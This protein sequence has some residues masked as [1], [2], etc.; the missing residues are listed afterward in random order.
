MKKKGKY[1]YIRLKGEQQEVNPR[2]TISPTNKQ[3]S[4]RSASNQLF[5]HNKTINNMRMSTI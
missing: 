2:I 5:I 3:G 4:Y 1:K